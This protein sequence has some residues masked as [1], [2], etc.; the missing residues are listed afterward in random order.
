MGVINFN[1]CPLSEVCP[2]PKV[3]LDEED[4]FSDSRHSGL[5]G[6]PLF[7]SFLSCLISQVGLSYTPKFPLSSLAN[8]LTGNSNYCTL[9]KFFFTA[10][11]TRHETLI[12]MIHFSPNKM[13]KTQLVKSLVKSH[14]SKYIQP[15]DSLWGRYNYI[16]LIGRKI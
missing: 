10:I 16:L 11:E 13:L 8:V 4:D 7:L 12:Q 6:S 5:S 9:F 15:D 3:H 2:S 1:V 14:G